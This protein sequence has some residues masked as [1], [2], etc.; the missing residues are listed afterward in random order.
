MEQ[1]NRNLPTIDWYKSL[2]SW[3]RPN[4]VAKENTVLTTADFIQIEN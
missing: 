1:I 2:S 4:T 3:I